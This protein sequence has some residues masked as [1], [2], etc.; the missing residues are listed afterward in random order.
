MGYV[1]REHHIC[2]LEMLLHLGFRSSMFST[3][4]T[5]FEILS[6][7]IRDD[8]VIM[9]TKETRAVVASEDDLSIPVI[10]DRTEILV[11]ETGDYFNDPDLKFI[12]TVV[13]DGKAF[14]VFQGRT[15]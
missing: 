13:S 6:V 14:H 7:G 9:W 11:Y 5:Y 15:R 10:I 1:I 2:T 4:N 12:G 8:N 3:V